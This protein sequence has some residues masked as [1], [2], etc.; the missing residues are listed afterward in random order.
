MPDRLDR[1]LGATR[2][3]LQCEIR[4]PDLAPVRARARQLRRRRTGLTVAASALALLLVIGLGTALAGGFGADRGPQPAAS[5]DPSGT[6]WQGAGV[7][8]HGLDGAVLDLP[9]TLVDVAFA[10]ADHGYALAADCTGSPCPLAVAAT[11]DGGHVWTAWDPPVASAPA[12]GLPRLIAVAGGLFLVTADDP[13]SGAW[14]RKSDVDG[15]TA[16]P[17]AGPAPV[18]GGGALRL[19]PDGCGGQLYGWTP[20]GRYARLPTPPPLTACAVTATP[21]SDGSW[22]VGGRSAAD[23]AP[24]VAVSHDR[25]V[26]W[27]VT[28]LPAGP[29]TAIVSVLGNRV[30]ATVVTDRGGDPYPETKILSAG[31]RSVDGGPFATYLTEPSTII[32]DVV[33]LLDGRLLAAGPDWQVCDG[34]T[35]TRA[36]GSLPWVRRFARTPG[37]WVAYDL[38]RGGWAAVSTNGQDWQ[39]LNVR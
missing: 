20:D 25:G 38:F 32:G 19:V 5:N 17:L 16:A 30:F 7:V 37:V 29:G 18:T 27:T 12:T 1:A 11:V 36:G 39:K 14:F 23:D 21:S 13:A 2:D 3:S 26:T 35:F 31:Y 4:T 22:W 24:A 15:W 28:V 33:P 10:D 9:G 34:T 6:L 8:M